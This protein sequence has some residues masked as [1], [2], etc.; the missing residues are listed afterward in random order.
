M[1]APASKDSEPGTSQELKPGRKLRMSCDECNKAKVKCAKDKPTCSRC[2][3]QKIQCVYGVSLRAGKRA[4]AQGLGRA[5]AQPQRFSAV[6]K[7]NRMGSKLAADA[8]S[9]VAPG[10]VRSSTP[11]EDTLDD[12]LH[13]F[14][15]SGNPSGVLDYRE[16]NTYST[17]LHQQ[18]MQPYNMDLLPTNTIDRTSDRLQEWTKHDSLASNNRTPNFMASPALQ[19]FNCDNTSNTASTPV[20]PSLTCSPADFSSPSSSVSSHVGLTIP[21]SYQTT[22]SSISAHCSTLCPSDLGLSVNP[23]P[24]IQPSA[25]S[26]LP[27]FKHSECQCQLA[28]LSVQRSL[29]RTSDFKSTSFDVALAD[30]KEIL[31]RCTIFIECECFPNDDSNVMLLSSIIARLI[32]V[33]W[34]G[35]SAL[36]MPSSTDA[37][38]SP[39][40]TANR[41]A[42]GTEKGSLTLGAYQFD[43]ADE[44]RLKMEIVLAELKKLEKLVQELQNSCHKSGCGASNFE[45]TDSKTQ[46]PRTFLWRSLSGFL[47]QRARSASM[48]LRSKV[49]TGENSHWG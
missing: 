11:Q 14:M 19:I 31:R 24:S 39:A 17:A 25:M 18:T 16:F 43:K 8:C 9:N 10:D 42:D 5:R 15:Y 41:L 26:P 46:D 13:S 27:N 2:K 44:E 38:A 34:T 3:G 12:L 21:G 45:G 37:F 36:G 7:K 23:Q 1:Y 29:L 6:T 48:D 4:A 22:P 32:S 49:L 33:Y 30:N 47:T 20:T 35:A 40:G 28:I